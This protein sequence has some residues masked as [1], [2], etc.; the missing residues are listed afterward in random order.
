MGG[1]IG[2]EISSLYYSKSE[3][4]SHNGEELLKKWKIDPKDL[5]QPLTK[6][7][8]TIL[9]KEKHVP[10]DIISLFS[11]D[12]DKQILDGSTPL[13]LAAG[14]Q[15][16]K[17]LEDMI[18]A[19][20]DSVRT[21]LYS[22]SNKN[23]SEEIHN[24]VQRITWN[25]RND[26]GLSP[27]S[28]AVRNQAIDAIQLLI[29]IGAD[30][31][32]LYCDSGTDAEQ[33]WAWSHL[34][35][36]AWHGKLDS[37]RVLLT[38]KGINSIWGKDGKRAIHLA[39]EN[40]QLEAVKILLDHDLRNFYNLNGE[41]SEV[42]K[43][44]SK[45]LAIDRF[46]VRAPDVRPSTSY[47][48]RGSAA[49]REDRTA[50]TAALDLLELLRGALRSDSS[51]EESDRTPVITEQTSAAD[52]IFT[53]ISSRDR[54]S[55]L[56]HLAATY[57]KKEILDFFLSH[58][59][60][61][62]SIRT[63]NE[64]GKAPIFMAVRNGHLSCVE[65][66]EAAGVEI[67]SADIENWTIMHEAVKYQHLDIVE[68]LIRNGADVNAS[69]DDGW[70]PLHVAARF[71]VPKS[72][73]IL[74]EAGADVNGITDE[75]ESVLQITVSQKNNEEML[76]E[77][78][79]YRPEFLT[80]VNSAVSPERTL[81]DRRD[82]KML[83]IYL[84]YIYEECR[85]SDIALSELKKTLVD[86]PMLLHR[87][88]ISNEAGI[89]RRLLQLGA[90]GAS[91]NQSGET[92]IFYASKK[93]MEDI[94]R[95]LLENHTNPDTQNRDGTR[96]IHAACDFGFVKIVEYLLDH[97]CDPSCQ[98][99]AT[100][101]NAG[102]T[103]LMLAARRGHSE[104][105]TVLHNYGVDMD[106]QK[107]D[108]YSALHLTALNGHIEALKALLMADANTELTEQNGFSPLHVAV[109][110]Q[111]FD[112]STALLTGG[113]DPRALGP[114][115]LSAL[116]FASH[117]CD[118]RS[119]W[120]LI[121]CGVPVSI[122]DE[123]EATA[124]HYCSRQQ[125][126]QSCI[127]LL[128]TCGGII[129]AIDTDGDTPLHCACQTAIIPNVRILLKRGASTKIK[130]NNGETPLHIAVSK[131]SESIVSSLIKHGAR[132]LEKNNDGETPYDIAVKSGNKEARLIIW[133]S[134]GR[135]IDDTIPET[136]YGVSDDLS[137][138]IENVEE[139]VTGSDGICV[140]CQ[141]EFRTGDS[142]RILP[143]RHQYHS[144]CIITWFGGNSCEENDYCPLCQASVLPERIEGEAYHL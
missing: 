128:L 122:V 76:K 144:S 92:A 106:T 72:V 87:C 101:P 98:V 74:V 71:S 58:P 20:L 115:G 34:R 28:I 42:Y 50:T 82:F 5:L 10:K 69:D 135:T 110:N 62:G 31:N 35:F 33:R 119:I 143:C 23:D 84:D 32:E 97:G 94:V 95:A 36:S 102:F 134:L 120:L 116:H 93:G 8:L 24:Q 1:T 70:T 44:A 80:T 53:S 140:I 25:A 3:Q 48:Q 112:A 63:L 139:R 11:E 117:V 136:V 66:F 13:H 54:G 30:P 45:T 2:K 56:L 67:Q 27:L 130:N 14:L 19:I 132:G 138:S 90:N 81:L 118:S 40:D 114:S 109:R 137:T 111:Q 47:S 43:D 21:E 7:K 4:N 127:Q 16:V 142:I 38:V 91:M 17:M 61:S 108:G 103:P 124:L 65:S 129:D 113:S 79:K 99:P 60:L 88:I 85:E 64:F 29:D 9:E 89:S 22:N 75:N 55:S 49:S 73:A 96:P 18:K 83:H 26:K 141:N 126:G 78:L 105:I 123:N 77:L 107:E 52:E 15:N 59:A 12:R 68:Y 6:E 86:N 121:Q 46:V 133:R 51:G 131:R 41:L 37:L 39:I 125:R 57:G 104:I 100:A